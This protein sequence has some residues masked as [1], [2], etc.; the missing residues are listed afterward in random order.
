MST[1]LFIVQQ[2]AIVCADCGVYAMMICQKLIQKC[3]T[4]AIEFSVISIYTALVF[5]FVYY[6]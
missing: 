1:C 4:T 6:K 2:P 5:A 3:T